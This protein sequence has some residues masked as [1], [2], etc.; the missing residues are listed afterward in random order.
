MPRLLETCERLWDNLINQ[1]MYLTGGIGPSRH[2][3]GFTADYDLPDETAYAETCATIGLVFWNQRLLQFE[4]ERRY[5]DVME[6]AL[7]NGFLSGVSLDGTRFFYENPLASAGDHHRAGWFELPLLPAER[8]PRSRQRRQLLLLDRPEAVSGCISSPGIPPRWRSDGQQGES[9]PANHV[10]LGR[11]GALSFDLAL[12]A[13]DLHPAPARARL[14]SELPTL[15]VNGAAGDLQPDENGYLAITREW[16]S[17]DGSNYEM[18]MPIQPVLANPAVRQLEGRVA[19]QRG[20]MVYCLEGVDHG[21]IILDRIS[22]DPQTSPA[23]HRRI[24]PRPAGRSN[25]D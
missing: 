2:N 14:V 11:R 8:G 1:R 6:R 15:E 22:V 13:A 10:P 17:G 18:D 7:Y 20:P 19:I 16:Q 9:H 4:G 21:G 23:I 12:A 3:E 24:S 25:G 5:A